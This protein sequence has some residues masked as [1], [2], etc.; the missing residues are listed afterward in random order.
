M[1]EVRTDNFDL[2]R[3]RVFLRPSFNRFLLQTLGKLH[4]PPEF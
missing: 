1:A 4:F 3:E 2:Q